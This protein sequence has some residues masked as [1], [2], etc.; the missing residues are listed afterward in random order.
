MN[1]LSTFGKILCLLLLFT[2]T[3]CA[4]EQLAESMG[5]SSSFNTPQEKLLSSMQN[6]QQEIPY[7]CWLCR[8]L[9]PRSG[10]NEAKVKNSE[11][12]DISIYDV[13]FLFGLYWMA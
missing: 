5:L 12:T 4:A 6:Q 11:V 3:T 1:S 8:T 2:F 13:M 9:E 7:Q 10:K